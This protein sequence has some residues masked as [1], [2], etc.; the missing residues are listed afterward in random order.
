MI[1][2]GLTALS[3]LLQAAVVRDDVAAVVATIVD[4]DQVLYSAAFGKRDVAAG[5]D[6]TS[7]AIFRI[8]S[9]TKPITS[10]AAMLLYDEGRLQLD[11]PVVSCL[12]DYRQPPVLTKLNARDGSSETRPASRPITVRDLLTHTSGIAY[13]FFNRSLAALVAAGTAPDAIPLLH[14][15]GADWTYGPNTAILARVVARVAGETIDAFC[16]ERIFRPLGMGDTAY[17]VPP[18]KTHRVV[19]Q[20][21]RVGSAKLVEQPNPPAI[22]SK[23]RGD[24][25]LLST[26]ADYATFLQLFLNRG[27]HHGRQIVSERALDLM[28]SN[29]IGSLTVGRLASNDASVIGP[30]PFGV[31]KDKFGLGFQIETE[32]SAPGMRSPGSL[33][34]SGVF[35]TYFWIDP[36]KRIAAVLLMQLLPAN[37]ERSVDLLRKFEALIYRHLSE[38]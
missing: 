27:R 21:R 1:D 5:D 24:D 36:R 19:T 31:G 28:T 15:P 33:S 8:A 10:L 2:A 29:Q 22:Q 38:A 14:D 6:L 13:P 16:H 9:M 17:E 30:F 25:G 7:D 11:E 35:N 37:D 34:W 26:A 20:H 12:P 4:G 23:G 3:G 32:P 18:G